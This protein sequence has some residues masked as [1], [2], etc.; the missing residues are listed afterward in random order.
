MGA[1]RVLLR[2]RQKASDRRE[3]KVGST[4]EVRLPLGLEGRTCWMERKTLQEE[5][6][7]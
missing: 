6:K 1:V 3:T 5:G 7:A 4:E 2:R